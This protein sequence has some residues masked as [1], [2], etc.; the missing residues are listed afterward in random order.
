LLTKRSVL[1]G[2]YIV[3]RASTRLTAAPRS[4]EKAEQDIEMKERSEEEA[5]NGH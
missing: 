4:G 2:E 1:R 3:T 5:L